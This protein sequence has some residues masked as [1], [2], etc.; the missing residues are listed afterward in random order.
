MLVPRT[1]LHESLYEGKYG[2]DGQVQK[3]PKGIA[4]DVS[5]AITSGKK[6]TSLKSLILRR[7]LCVTEF[8]CA[9]G[10]RA[11]VHRFGTGPLLISRFRNYI[12]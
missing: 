6:S 10:F 11:V 9:S 7:M 8:L 4:T 12:K 2:L 1:F 5:I 3:E